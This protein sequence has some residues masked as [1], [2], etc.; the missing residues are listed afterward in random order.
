[1][2]GEYN[3]RN[4]F[5]NALLAI[6]FV[7]MALWF[8]LPD[9]CCQGFSRSGRILGNANPLGNFLFGNRNP[10]FL[11]DPAIPGPFGVSE[12][13]VNSQQPFPTRLD[14]GSSF[15]NSQL[16]GANNSASLSSVPD[17]FGDFFG[18]RP[19]F[20]GGG[21]VQNGLPPRGGVGT[22]SI[23]LSENLS[24]QPRSRVF[25]SYH[26][27]N[28]VFDGAFGDVN[29]YSV[30]V[31]FA[32][33]AKTFSLDIR[34]PVAHT[35]S[36]LQVNQFPAFKDTEI[37]NATF[38]L[39]QVIAANECSLVSAGLGIAIPT[40]EDGILLRPGD[41]RQILRVEN[42]AVHLIPF[43]GYIREFGPRLFSQGFV[44]LDIDTSG[45]PVL[46]DV[47][48]FNLQPL[49][50]VQDPT[51][52]FVDIGLGYRVFEN[53]RR[54]I[55]SMSLAAEFHYATTVQDTDRVNQAGFDV[56]DVTRRYDVLNFTI[57]SNL[58]IGN[59]V[60]RP[61]FVVPLRERQDRQFDFE[62]FLQL[63]R[64]Y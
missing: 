25:F 2:A 50:I 34:I 48:A 7:A 10:G 61:G 6:V 22:R 30:G 58:G 51:L 36:N 33:A 54:M 31:E 53:R 24:P 39:K 5:Y 19:P 52:L 42:E 59:T 17:M 4:T 32:N 38:I 18:G 21:N 15:E 12:P 41:L 62:A 49:G 44:Q 29:R 27:F 40:A 1:M 45:N 46:G 11:Y 63:N 9:A 3:Q 23:K 60:L 16:L 8:S 55:H 56:G 47:N 57:G 28:D 20:G 64:Y 26:F 43:V 35:L 14:S 37:G 13:F